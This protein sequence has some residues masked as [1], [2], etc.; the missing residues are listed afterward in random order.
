LPGSDGDDLA[1]L[2]RAARSAGDVARRFFRGTYWTRDKGAEGPVTEADIAVNETLA[3]ILRPARPGYGWLSE[4]TPDGPARLAAERVF[5]L[6]PIDGT[7]AFIDGQD[8][9]AHSLAIAAQGRV[10]AAVVYLPIQ[11]KLYA[12]T[13]DGPATLNGAPIRCT[14]RVQAEGATTLTARTTLD[15]AHWRNATPPPVTRAFRPSL[16]NR[17][18]LVADGSFDAM[19]TLR[20]TWEWDIAAGSLIAE[21]AGA[22]VTD[23]HGRALSF[24]APEARADGVVAAGTGLW[25]SLTKALA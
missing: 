22:T 17:L 10:T 19:L 7:R 23:R 11:N 12:A 21:R 9:F 8:G 18:C 20:P 1:L 3:A 13:P 25:H 2:T 24:N 16:A 4:E 5:L 6:D 14:N 15:P